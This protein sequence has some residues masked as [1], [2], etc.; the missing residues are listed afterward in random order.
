MPE[1]E[2]K[3]IDEWAVELMLMALGYSIEVIKDLVSD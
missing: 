2:S 1:S 3:G